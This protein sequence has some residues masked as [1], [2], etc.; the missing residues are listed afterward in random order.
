M[1]RSGSFEADFE[2]IAERLGGAVGAY[3]VLI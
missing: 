1:A 2:S 3:E